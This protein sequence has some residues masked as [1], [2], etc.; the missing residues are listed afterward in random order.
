M[1]S[2]T[3]ELEDRSWGMLSHKRRMSKCAFD[4]Y[5]DI[6]KRLP[7]FCPYWSAM[8]MPNQFFVI[9]TSTYLHR[10][11]TN[12]MWLAALHYHGVRCASY[13]VTQHSIFSYVYMS[14]NVNQNQAD[15]VHL[16]LLTNQHSWWWLWAVTEASA[17]CGWCQ[18][19]ITEVSVYCGW[20]RQS[21]TKVST[22]KPHD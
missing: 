7:G 14:E 10:P 20:C 11:A 22:W 3:E 17:Y 2:K 8:V 6:S 18:Q 1:W 12:A 15:D 4:K 19:S 5:A 16:V 9:P 21:V 13:R